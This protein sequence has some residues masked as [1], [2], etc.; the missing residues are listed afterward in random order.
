MNNMLD[1]PC[2]LLDR[3][4]DPVTQCLTPDA[5]RRRDDLAAK[6]NEGTLTDEE[7]AEHFTMRGPI[8]SGST[9]IGRATVRRLQMN[10]STRVVLRSH[11]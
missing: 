3:I 6:S 4:L 1:T 10:G 11:Q 8:I 2:D 5:Q 7:R 9:P